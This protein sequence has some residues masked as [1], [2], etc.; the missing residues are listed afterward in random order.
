MPQTILLVPG[1]MGS[2]LLSSPSVFGLIPGVP[3]WLSYAR[4]AAGYWKQLAL[5]PSGRQPA[6]TSYG[7]LTPGGPIS[8]YLGGFLDWFESRGYVVEFA[9][10]DWRS[11]LQDDGERVAA[12]I[13]TLGSK[14]PVYIVC[15]SRGGL[16]VRW[17]LSNF[18]PTEQRAFVKG[19]VGLGVPHQG[20][21]SAAALLA[22][23]SVDF[24]NLLR[25]ISLGSPGGL[26]FN[27]FDGVRRMASTW[28]SPYMLMPSPKAPWITP[29]TAA[30][31]YDPAAWSA[32]GFPVDPDWLAFA[33]AGW[34][35]IPPTPTPTP[36][37]DVVGYSFPTPVDSTGPVPPKRLTD[38]ASSPDGDG[39]VLVRSAAIADHLRISAP[40][41]H[42]AL[43]RDQ[44]I[45]KAIDRFMRGELDQDVVIGPPS[46][47]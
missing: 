47:Q 25:V 38:L 32:A 3:V 20:T 2:Q 30:A 40:T 29:A 23:W 9:N 42:D 15:H 17:A 16:V 18:A 36:W 22:G 44:R 26:I 12:Q 27:G 4:I 19:V 7:P 28:P 41:A 35:A 34:A 33:A 14:D 31:L 39:T 21:W 24:Q 37:V 45:Y 8:A 5:G 10:V 46:V 1:F 13:R 43:V 11:P 6:D